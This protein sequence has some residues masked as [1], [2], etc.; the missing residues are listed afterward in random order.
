[1]AIEGAVGDFLAVVVG[2]S[3]VFFSDYVF[4]LFLYYNGMGR[5]KPVREKN[6]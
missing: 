5:G 1:V 4:I 6:Y 2:V 3:G